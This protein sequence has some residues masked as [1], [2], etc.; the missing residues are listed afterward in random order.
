LHQLEQ[1]GSKTLELISKKENPIH[2]NWTILVKKLHEKNLRSVNHSSL[3]QGLDKE[4]SDQA[5]LANLG[6]NDSI[7]RAA[8]CQVNGESRESLQ[9][10]FRSARL[11]TILSRIFFCYKLLG[12]IEGTTRWM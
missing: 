8:I 6:N 2:T 7:I 1:R 3:T 9:L 12:F 11:R 5:R 10:D 4:P